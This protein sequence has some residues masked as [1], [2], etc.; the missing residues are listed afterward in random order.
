MK[1]LRIL[2]VAIAYDWVIEELTQDG[3][4]SFSG[5]IT[6]GAKALQ[7][8]KLPPQLVE[9]M[10]RMVGSYVSEQLGLEEGSFNIK[11]GKK[12]EEVEIK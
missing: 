9:E 12:G 8:E 5:T 11:Y 2:G 7:A 3:K 1:T 10:A 4:L 6:A